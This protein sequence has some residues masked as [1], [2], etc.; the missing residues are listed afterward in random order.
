[1]LA[2]LA[3]GACLGDWRKWPAPPGGLLATAPAD[4]PAEPPEQ[5]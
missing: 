5:E 3:L 1:M 4:E 2:G